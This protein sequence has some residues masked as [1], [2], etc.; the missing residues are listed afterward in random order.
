MLSNSHTL[1]PLP[2]TALLGLPQALLQKVGSERG[3]KHPTQ[4]L[5]GG[6]NKT[7]HSNNGIFHPG[8]E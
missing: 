7:L 6:N 3:H 2:Q 8:P 4:T 1:T 5:A